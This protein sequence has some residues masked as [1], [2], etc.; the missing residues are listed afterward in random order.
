MCEEQATA[1]AT[2]IGCVGRFELSC[3][4]PVDSVVLHHAGPYWVLDTLAF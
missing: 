1:T 4:K 2:V 3:S